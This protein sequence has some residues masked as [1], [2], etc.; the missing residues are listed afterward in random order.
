MEN[1]EIIIDPNEKILAICIS[2]TKSYLYA[3]EQC[4]RGITAAVSHYNSGHFIYASDDSK[5]CKNALEFAKQNLPANWQIHNIVFKDL[6]DK[7]EKYQRQSQ[8]II[9]K[10]QGATFHKARQIKA[11]LCFSV[12]SDVILKG[13][14]LRVL[15]WALSMPAADGSPIYDISSGTYNNSSPLLGFGTPQNPIAEDFLPHERKLKP[16][17]KLVFEEC[18]KR[19]KSFTKESKKEQIEKEHKRMARIYKVIKKCPP[20]GNIWEITSK[21]G[22]R[23]RGWWENAMPGAA[24]VAHAFHSDWCGLGNTLM[25]KKALSLADFNG[26]DGSGTQDLYLCWKKWYPAGLKIIGVP[27]VY[28]DHIKQRED[29]IEHLVAFRETEGECKDHMRCKVQEFIPL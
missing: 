3:W 20:D 15:E 2:A 29:K 21:Y 4:I 1:K 6:N 5:E 28:C 10:L 8:I 19:I 27:Y 7:E 12:E 23:R 24:S 16:R 9:A 14:S 13:D 25:S 18:E 22:F 26:Y 17:I 11:D